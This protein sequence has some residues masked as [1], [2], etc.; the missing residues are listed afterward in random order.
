MHGEILAFDVLGEGAVVAVADTGRDDMDVVAARGET[1]GEPL[2]E[3]GGSV[4]VG[5]ERVGRHHDG[6]RRAFGVAVAGRGR[7]RVGSHGMVAAYL[8]GVSDG[9]CG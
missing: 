6:Q 9:V 2:G 7:C 3:T 4:D 5:S 8:C 1:G